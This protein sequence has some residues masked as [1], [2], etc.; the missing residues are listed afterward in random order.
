MLDAVGVLE[1]S[2]KDAWDLQHA[3]RGIARANSNKPRYESQTKKENFC[4]GYL[5]KEIVRSFPK[6]PR[7][8]RKK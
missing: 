2:S 4:A 8:R 6:A 7:T 1:N 3:G 5:K